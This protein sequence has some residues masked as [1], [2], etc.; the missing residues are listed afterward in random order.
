MLLHVVAMG[1]GKRK[2]SVMGLP[3][4]REGVIRGS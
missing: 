1:Y 4:T 2:S 3:R